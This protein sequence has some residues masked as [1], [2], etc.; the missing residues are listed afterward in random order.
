MF[1][2]AYASEVFPLQLHVIDLIK[3]HEW[4]AVIEHLSSTHF[5]SEVSSCAYTYPRTLLHIACTIPSVP[6]DVIQ[7]LTTLYPYACLAEDEDGR[8]PIHLASTT[9]GIH[10]QVIRI[11]MI[12]S[13]ESCFKRDC[14]DE[15]LP[16]YLLLKYNSLTNIDLDVKDLISSIPTACVYNEEIS[17]AHGFCYEILPEIILNQIIKTYPKVCHIHNDNG[18]TLL[19]LLCS[20]KDSTLQTI[21]D[22]TNEYPQACAEKNYN[23]DL[24]L[25]LVSTKNEH[26]KVIKLLLNVYP[27]SI[28]KSNAAGQIPLLTQNF[29]ESPMKVKTVL[30]HSDQANIQSLLHTR[31]HIDLLPVEEL[32]YRI[33]CD[34]SLVCH[35]RGILSSF[36]HMQYGLKVTNQTKSL[37]YLMRAYVNG[38][39]DNMNSGNK[40]NDVHTNFFWTAFPLFTKL[41]LQHF[42]DLIK[43][44]D[45]RGELPLHILAKDSSTSSIVHQCSICSVFPISGPY[46]WYS[47]DGTHICGHC[48][49]KSS[50]S[51]FN[52]LLSPQLPL[53]M[54]L[55][56]Y[57]SY[58]LVNDALKIY[59]QAAS[60]PDHNG[61]L[62][63]HLGLYAGKTWNSG[64]KEIFEAAPGSN[65][66]QD[67][68][69][70][71]F[72]F[73]L[74]ASKN[75][76]DNTHKHIKDLASRELET[77][78]S[79]KKWTS[80][81][82]LTTIFALLRRAPF[83]VHNSNMSNSQ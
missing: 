39:E 44:K 14:M 38:C 18:D 45:C 80:L 43:E 24:P 36:L 32:F 51:Y 83:Q 35:S 34:L 53:Q 2:G 62:P 58:E 29:R 25:H 56:E 20:H 33:Q 77:E 31:N 69:T 46:F 73:M 70:H 30:S 74:A 9:A 13:P 49:E 12:A 41:L 47:A 64:I 5:I 54:P 72:P 23:G 78:I 19:H 3:E 68:S 71:L 57:Q 28:F 1:E 7:I 48:S 65:F 79:L 4:Q 66:I 21:F 55:I 50:H 67:R 6:A 76:N 17:L 75:N 27:C 59:P 81:S 37:K 22:V 10:L 26:E 60:I 16:V 63:L 61:N 8:L 42:P 11:L 82:E 15:E 40:F 52:N